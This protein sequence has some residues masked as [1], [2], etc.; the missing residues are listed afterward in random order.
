MNTAT[1][2]AIS[3]RNSPNIS[4]G[5]FTIVH[6]SPA[7]RRI[8]DAPSVRSHQ[9][10]REQ[11]DRVTTADRPSKASASAAKNWRARQVRESSANL[12]TFGNRGSSLEP[13]NQNRGTRTL[14]PWNRGTL[15]PWNPYGLRR[16]L[17]SLRWR[18]T[19]YRPAIDT[20]IPS[21]ST[22]E[23]NIRTSYNSPHLQWIS[24]YG[25]S[26]GTCQPR[27]ACPTEPA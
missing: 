3:L 25:L 10:L 6:G 11:V 9:I 23:A 18:W 15:E 12:R 1:R 27:A 26:Q 4:T 13:W 16:E 21:T 5:V 14:E 7:A 22:G 19:R 20:M 8:C 24:R 17:R 2:T